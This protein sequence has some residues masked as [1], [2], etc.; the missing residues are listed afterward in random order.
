[1]GQIIPIL[2]RLMLARYRNV[3][4]PREDWS[5]SLANL[6]KHKFEN[7]DLTSPIFKLSSDLL[8]QILQ[9]TKFDPSILEISKFLYEILSPLFT[10]I[11]V[12]ALRDSTHGIFTYTK[13]GYV[14][15]NSNYSHPPEDAYSMV[16]SLQADLTFKAYLIT[17]KLDKKRKKKCYSGTWSLGR[18][19]NSTVVCFD[20]K[21]IVKVAL[22]GLT[23]QNKTDWSGCKKSLRKPCHVLVSPNFWS[24]EEESD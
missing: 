2:A 12:S 11:D 21:P 1:M 17:K 5:K 20:P 4:P 13:N 9:L 14:F 3:K 19:D 10:F 23:K 16:V 15:P 6:G 22:D 24:P 8:V 18:E 7:H